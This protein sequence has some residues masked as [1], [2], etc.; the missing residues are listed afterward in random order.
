MKKDIG[1]FMDIERFVQWTYKH[2]SCFGSTEENDRGTAK[3][4]EGTDGGGKSA[5]SIP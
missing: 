2:N 4:S 3:R 5:V 1:Y